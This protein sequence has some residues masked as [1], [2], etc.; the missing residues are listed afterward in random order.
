MK[1]K[2]IIDYV[3]ILEEKKLEHAENENGIV[4]QKRK[5]WKDQIIKLVK[6][7]EKKSFNCKT[8]KPK[9]FMRL[10]KQW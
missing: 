6:E 3:I 10:R 8:R 5:N 4:M 9:V 2:H 7:M 1:D